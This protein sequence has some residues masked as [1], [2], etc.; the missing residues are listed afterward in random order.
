MDGC[1]SG[2][3]PDA[4]INLVFSNKKS[5]YGL[6]RAQFA[7]PS[8]PTDNIALQPFLSA[9]PHLT[10]IDYDLEIARRI[11]SKFQSKSKEEDSNSNV[12]P[13]DSDSNSDS[14]STTSSE[15]SKKI[16]IIVLAGFMHVL[17][18]EFLD[19]FNGLRDY[20]H[21]G[22]KRRVETPIPIINLHPALPGAFDGA[23]AIERAFEAYKRGEITNTGVMVHHVVKEVDRGSP[24]LV[25]EVEIL[26]EDTL[27]T[28]EERIHRTE[29]NLL[30]EG[31]VKVLFSSS[32]STTPELATF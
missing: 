5:A 8:I 19:V 20:E 29:H 3:I 31:I 32:S 6:I 17:S 12:Q 26:P 28:L 11:L 27:A 13:N 25:R 10:R 30:V 14:Y 18:A 15:S 22:I 2:K 7:S 21:D 23:N 1:A 4:E 9:N 24:I 16:D